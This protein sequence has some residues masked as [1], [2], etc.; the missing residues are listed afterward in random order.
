MPAADPGVRAELEPRPRPRGW[1][2]LHAELARSTR[3]P[4][5]RLAPADSQRIQRAL[6][7]YRVS[8]API[9]SLQQSPQAGAPTHPTGRHAAGVA[10]AARPRLAARA[11]RA[12]FR[13]HAA[14]GLCWTK[15]APC[16]RAATCTPT[17]PPCAA[18][19]IARP[20]RRWT[21]A[22]RWRSCASAASPPHAS[23][24]SARSP[25]CARMPQRQVV[26]CDAPDALAAGAGAGRWLGD[27][28]SCWSSACQAL[29][30][31]DRVR[32][33]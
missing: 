20:G 22:S 15:Y 2:A 28:M 4:R 8:G 18:W 30:R 14:G 24:P 21:A 23:S 29:W 17:C 5:A 19:A 10:G 16:A 7:V 31:G 26:A 27:A 1:P 32:P 6:E 9:S 3:S 13:R 25:G 33:T 11:H 12:A